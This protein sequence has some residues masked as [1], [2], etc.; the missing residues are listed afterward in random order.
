MANIK[1]RHLLLIEMTARIIKCIINE[2]FRRVMQTTTI[3]LQESYR[4]IV[5]QQFNKYLSVSGYV[6]NNSIFIK[7]FFILFYFSLI[8]DFFIL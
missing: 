6:N 7:L 5:I 1:W 2:L 3:P 8:F 4:Q